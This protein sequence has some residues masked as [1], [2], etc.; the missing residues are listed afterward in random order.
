MEIFNKIKIAFEIMVA[1]ISS[2]MIDLVD[3]FN[4]KISPPFRE[5]V[6]MLGLVIFILMLIGII[7]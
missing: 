7:L 5:V 6:I 3:I 2:F 4:S 1:E